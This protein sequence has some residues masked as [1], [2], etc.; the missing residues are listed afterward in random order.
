MGT[1]TFWFALFTLKTEREAYFLG[2]K[3]TLYHD[4]I[5]ILFWLGRW[6]EKSYTYDLKSV[7]AY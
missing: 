5:Q 7:L 3:T 6:P 2:L 1:L 4:K